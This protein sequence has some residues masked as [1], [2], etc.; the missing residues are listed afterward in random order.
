MLWG[1]LK[2]RVKHLKLCRNKN[3]LNLFKSVCAAGAA[4]LCLCCTRQSGGG[5]K[6]PFAMQL[7]DY[8]DLDLLSFVRLH[9]PSI[10]KI[11]DRA[12]I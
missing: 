3:Q 12:F 2:H 5:E 10:I 6:C 7:A 11:F 1:M 8:L 4:A 9:W